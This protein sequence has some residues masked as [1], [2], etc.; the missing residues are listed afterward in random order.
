ML[1]GIKTHC[2]IDYISDV[3]EEVHLDLRVLIH[4]DDAR[5][6]K[7][8]GIAKTEHIIVDPADSEIPSPVI[9]FE[10]DR[11]CEHVSG[12]KYLVST[13]TGT[14][15]VTRHYRV[16]EKE[17]LSLHR[18]PFDQQILSIELDTYS[19][20]F[21][22]WFAPTHDVP[23]GFRSDAESWMTADNSTSIP[24]DEWKLEWSHSEVKNAA[25]QSCFKLLAG[26]KRKSEFYLTNCVLVV[27]FI[28]LCAISVIAVH[29]SDFGSRGSLT[30]TILLTLVAFKFVMSSYV[31]KIPY[32]T[33]LDYYNF[34]AIVLV[35]AVI[36]ENF[37]VS[38][39]FLHSEDDRG[40]ADR[41][42]AIFYV[43]FWNTYSVAIFVG[44]YFGLFY[45]SWDQQY[46]IQRRAVQKYSN[47]SCDLI[48]DDE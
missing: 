1:A 23:S 8:I 15:Y 39:L 5:A 48:V 37:L 7:Y 32:F 3:D 26:I 46:E 30:F 14:I 42:F 33:V 36:L 43:T 20:K 31:P 38:D 6:Q 28:V 21:T 25:G 12:F 27:Y 16:V 18:F 47:V 44:Y 24:G 2:A 11:L 10:N 41:N 13:K 35:V 17:T 40:S 29:P 19:L 45:R 4:F 34:V 22:K 9:N